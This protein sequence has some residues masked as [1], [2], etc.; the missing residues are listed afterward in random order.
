MITNFL[1]RHRKWQK[2][3][4]KKNI[5]VFTNVNFLNV[6]WLFKTWTMMSLH[7]IL[8]IVALRNVC[9]FGILLSSVHHQFAQISQVGKPPPIYVPLPSLCLV[10]KL[11]ITIQIK[12]C[13]CCRKIGWKKERA[14]QKIS[15]KRNLLSEKRKERENVWIKEQIRMNNLVRKVENKIKVRFWNAFVDWENRNLN[16]RAGTSILN[17]RA[18]CQLYFTTFLSRCSISVRAHN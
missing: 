3:K 9:L 10:S 17:A 13:N 4:K 18:F 11:F 6:L 7:N 15:F 14:G 5:K 16:N 12:Q 8:F 1:K 2:K